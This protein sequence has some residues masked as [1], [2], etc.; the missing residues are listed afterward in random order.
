[1]IVSKAVNL[2]IV[3]LQFPEDFL[4][5]SWSPVK[6]FLLIFNLHINDVVTE[7]L[8]LGRVWICAYLCVCSTVPVYVW[9]VC[10]VICVSVCFSGCLCVC[11][12]GCLRVFSHSE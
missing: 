6:S 3:L 10:V 1:M 12:Q 8:I 7:G 2:N 5:I 11:V 9:C 4:F